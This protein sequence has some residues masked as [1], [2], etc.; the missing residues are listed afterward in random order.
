MKL[1]FSFPQEP[2][3][4]PMITLKS[5]STLQTNKGTTTPLVKP[6]MF[7]LRLFHS[8]RKREIKSQKT[9]Y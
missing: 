7:I 1:P 4:R 9:G 2:Q 8:I 3:V 5:P 6:Q